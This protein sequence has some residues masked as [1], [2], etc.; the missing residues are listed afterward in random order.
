MLRPPFSKRV[1]RAD[2]VCV[3]RGGGGG[4]GGFEIATQRV[5]LVTI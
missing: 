2:C 4:L 5:V 1:V 3:W